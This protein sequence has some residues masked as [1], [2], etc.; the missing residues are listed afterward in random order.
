MVMR[1]VLVAE[2]QQFALGSTMPRLYGVAVSAWAIV[3]VAIIAIAASIYLILLTTAASDIVAAVM[4]GTFD[5]FG[6]H[7]FIVLAFIFS[8][9]LLIVMVK[10]A[11]TNS[12]PQGV[13]VTKD[14]FPALEN[15][16]EQC[17]S[18][19]RIDPPGA[20]FIDAKANASAWS[21]GLFTSR[22]H[23]S[24]TLRIGAPFLVCLDRKDLA[25]IL[26]H[27]F[28]H[29]YLRRKEWAVNLENK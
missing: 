16:V 4:N 19:A 18:R 11:V 29:I 14:S 7:L 15:L 12:R 17:V 20:I 27:E 13:L 2:R 25:A 28:G 5:P 21:S 9:G 24:S 10:I 26:Y 6:F 22:K 1:P 8:A 3:L 23:P